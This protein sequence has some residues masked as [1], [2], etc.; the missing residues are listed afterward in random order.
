MHEYYE[1]D[2]VSLSIQLKK[3][4]NKFDQSMLTGSSFEEVKKI[5]LEI[6]RIEAELKVT[7]WSGQ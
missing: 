1:N 7:V 5:Y 3:L 2:V 6:K 4:K